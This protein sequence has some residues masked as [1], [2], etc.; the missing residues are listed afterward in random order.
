MISRIRP[1]SDPQIWWF[2]GSVQDPIPRYHEID[3][4]QVPIHGLD[5][6][7]V[8]LSTIWNESV[9]FTIHSRVDV[10]GVPQEELF[11]K[12]T[13]WFQGLTSPGPEMTSKWPKSGISR[14]WTPDLMISRTPPRS[15]PQIW[16]FP[17]P[18]QDP[19]PRYH[20]FDPSQVP[21]HGLDPFWGPFDGYLEWIVNITHSFH[22]RRHWG[23]PEEL[24]GK[25]TN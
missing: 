11:G 3:P 20:D 8:H 23:T 21:I 14:I 2:P 15:D 6:F 10:I 4:S 25:S 1:R 9:I 22:V 5:P 19:I 17:G 18:L 16:W 13:K 24:L 7:W 12:R